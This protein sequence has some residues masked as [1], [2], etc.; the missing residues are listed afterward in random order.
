[1]LIAHNGVNH[2]Q[3]KSN[4]LETET[5]HQS[6]TEQPNNSQSLE[7]QTKPTAIPPNLIP[8]STVKEE[9][10]ITPQLETV[11]LI[12]GLGESIFTLLIASPF[13]LLGFKNWLHK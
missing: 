1:M 3:T 2:Q 6:Q 9:T 10:T 5:H 13:L 12:P 4:S 7:V 11:T 8:K